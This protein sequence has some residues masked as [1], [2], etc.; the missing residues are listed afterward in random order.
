MLKLQPAIWLKKRFS[1]EFFHEN[2]PAVA[3][4]RLAVDPM[5]QCS[6][7]QDVL[8][9]YQSRFLQDRNW[10]TVWKDFMTTVP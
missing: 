2:M 4:M 6:D 10:W 8:S 9:T 7:I 5:I 3:A 1:V